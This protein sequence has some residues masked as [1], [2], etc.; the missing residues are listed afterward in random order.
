M[1]GVFSKYSTSGLPATPLASEFFDT[2][3]V[4]IREN[5]IEKWFSIVA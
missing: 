1:I 4:P 5:L 2:I 3:I